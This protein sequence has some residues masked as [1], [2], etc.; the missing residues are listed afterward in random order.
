MAELSTSA[1]SPMPAHIQ[2]FRMP[3]LTQLG[4]WLVALL[5]LWALSRV[6]L[7]WARFVLGLEGAS[8]FVHRM[9]PPVFDPRAELVKGLLETLQIAVLASAAGVVLALPMGL[10]AARNLMPSWIT[11]LARFVITLCRTF[12]PIIVAIV[13]VKA[14]GLGVLASILALT[15]AS[16]SSRKASSMRR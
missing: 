8:K 1:R 6:D 7:T 13:F 10:L 11:W 3:A 5:M 15:V 16:V 4:W 14:V 9:F 2:P 12:H